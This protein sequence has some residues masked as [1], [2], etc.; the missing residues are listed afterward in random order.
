MK[1]ASSLSDIVRQ[2]THINTKWDTG[3]CNQILKDSINLLEQEMK[4]GI[5][6]FK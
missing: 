6:S 3:G 1:H 2:P 4:N 5:R